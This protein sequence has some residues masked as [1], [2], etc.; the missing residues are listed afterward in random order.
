MALVAAI[1]LQAGQSRGWE[2]VWARGCTA[3]ISPLA[4]LLRVS[5]RQDWDEKPLVWAGASFSEPVISRVKKQKQPSAAAGHPTVL[6][7]VH[8]CGEQ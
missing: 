4:S 6:Q 3:G 8:L 1:A 7:Q 2:E 5:L